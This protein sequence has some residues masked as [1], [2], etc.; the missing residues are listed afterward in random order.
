MTISL[1]IITLF[2]A[3]ALSNASP[4]Q[5]S[6]RDTPFGSTTCGTNPALNGL[7]LSSNLPYVDVRQDCDTA[8]NAICQWVN[9]QTSQGFT[10]QSYRHITGECEGHFFYSRKMVGNPKTYPG[11][12]YAT[13]VKNFQSITI[14]CMLPDNSVTTRQQ[15]GVLDVTYTPAPS[16]LK[17][18]EQ[19]QLWTYLDSDAESPGYMM[20]AQRA[21]GD[22]A[23][24]FGTGND[25]PKC[26]DGSVATP[27][28]ACPR[29]NG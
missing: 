21:F 20:G 27:N 25:L 5:I 19:S 4:F 7:G 14:D 10:P 22:E 8:I 29:K 28:V 17:A 15:Y 3:I 16:D 9:Y 13:C 26:D 6:K 11:P 24:W 23:K 2:T 1:R 12:D 18:G